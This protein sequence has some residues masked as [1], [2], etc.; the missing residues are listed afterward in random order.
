MDGRACD[1]DMLAMIQCVVFG[2]YDALEFFFAV[3]IPLWAIF[4][5]CRK[6]IVTHRCDCFVRTCNDCA[7]LSRRILAPASHHRCEVTEAHVP[8]VTQGNISSESSISSCSSCVD[9]FVKSRVHTSA[10]NAVPINI[11]KNALIIV[12]DS[13]ALPVFSHTAFV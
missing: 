13:F 1:V 8:L 5:F 3:S 6:A 9:S 12:F 4:H 2:M 7:D 10:A 11:I